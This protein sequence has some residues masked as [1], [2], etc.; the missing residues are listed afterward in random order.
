MPVV[1]F[2]E[3]RAAAHVA[4]FRVPRRL[5]ARLA[6]ATAGTPLCSQA[7][8]PFVTCV[9]LDRTDGAFEA[10]LASLGLTEGND[11]YHFC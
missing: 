9:A 1:H 10:N 8:P 7:A 2:R 3:A 4:H 5:S 11:F 6:H